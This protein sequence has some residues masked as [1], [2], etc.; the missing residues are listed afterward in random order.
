MSLIRILKCHRVLTKV[1]KLGN[2]RG[3][4]SQKVSTITKEHKFFTDNT[5]CPTCTQSI[6]E[7]FRIDRINDAKSK[8]KELEKVSKN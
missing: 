5:V 2:L 1:K 6:N 7:E 8:A 4:L 3:K